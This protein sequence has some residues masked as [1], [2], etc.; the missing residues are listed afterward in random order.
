MKI[1][2][3]AV[4]FLLLIFSVS[5]IAGTSVCVKYPSNLVSGSGPMPYNY[6]VIDGHIHTGGHPLDPEIDLKASDETVL[7]VLNY[8]KS[9]GIRHFID[10]ENTRAVQ[11]RYSSLLEK[12]GIERYHVPMHIAKVPTPSE[13]KKIK[14]LMKGPVYIHCKWGADRT[15]MV[16]AKY[17]IEEKGYTTGEAVEAVKTGGS[18]SGVKGGLRT[19]LY[20]PT[21]LWFINRK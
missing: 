9:K 18:H 17:L 8:L 4:C 1:K 15:G 11:A 12:A 2:S 20:Y 3:A 14:E 19:E 5:S 21:L 7:S 6:H 16:I 10:L 13:W